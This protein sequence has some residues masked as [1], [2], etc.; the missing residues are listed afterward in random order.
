MVIKT[1]G[2]GLRAY[3]MDYHNLMDIFIVVTSWIPVL[4]QS[5]DKSIDL[6]GLKFLRVLRPLR[7]VRNIKALKVIVLSIIRAVPL[8]KS[9]FIILLFV[10][11]VF[12]VLMLHL[13]K[14][15]FKQMC[16]SAPNGLPTGLFYPSSIP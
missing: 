12:A 4:V 10:Y 6:S 13:Q 3:V 8:L 15:N 7:T 11:V 1:I 16:F 2:L 9:I 14:G 5:P